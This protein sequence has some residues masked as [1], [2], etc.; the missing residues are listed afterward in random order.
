MKKL[1]NTVLIVVLSSSFALVKAQSEV[2]RDS[3]KTKEMQGV[4]IT[5]L[6]IKREQKQLGYSFQDVKG[7]DLADNPTVSVAQ[8]LYGKVAGVNISQ[9]A[10]GIASSSRV[11]IRGNRS[12]G[13]DNQPLYI[14]D[15]VPLGNTQ[16]GALTADK[17]SK[18]ADGVDNGDG[19]SSLNQEDIENISVLKGGAASALYGER[20]ANGVIIITTKKGKKN[21]FK[22]DFNSTTT[23]DVINTNYKDYQHLYGTGNNG[24]VPNPGELTTAQGAT[25]SA[26]GPKLGSVDQVRIFDGSFKPYTYVKNNIKNFFNTGVTF[27]NNISVSGGGQNI[28]YRLSYGNINAKDIIPRSEFKR[29]TFLIGLNSEF[30][31][32]SLEAKINYITEEARNRPSLADDPNNVGFSLAGLAPN[33][34]EAYLKHYQ[35]NNGNYYPWNGNAFRLNPYYVLSETSNLTNR[36]RI[37]G[38]ISAVYKLTDWLSLT[39]RAGID[40][41]TFDSSDFINSGHTWPSRANGYLSIGNL[42]FQEHNFEGLLNAQKQFGDFNVNLG[43]GANERKT[44]R[45]SDGVIYTNIINKGEIKPANF[46]SSSVYPTVNNNILVRSV[47]SYL[48]TSYK[49]YLFL[50]FTARNDWNSTLASPTG[51]DNNNNYSFFYP[52]VSSSFV[53]SDAFNLKSDVFTFGKVR[54]SWA[55]TGKAPEAPYLTSPTYVINSIPL[56]GNS[57][58]GL[59]STVAPNANLKPERSNTYEFGFDLAFFKN[60]FELDATYYHTRTSD[61]NIILNTSTTSAFTGVATNAGLVENKGIEALLRAGIFRNNDNGFNWDVTLNFAANNNKLLELDGK[62]DTQVISNARWA[63]AQIIAKVGESSSQIY[64]KKFKRTADGQIILDANGLPLLTDTLESLGKAVPDWIGG[65]VNEFS[66]KGIS[67]RAGL[68]M[69]FGGKVYSMTNAYAAASGLTNE[70]LAGREE[71]N[72]WVAQQLAAG[73]TP[74]EIASMQP[75]AGLI[76]KGVIAVNNDPNQPTTYVANTK[77]VNPQD[78][79]SRLYGDD[80]TPEPFIYDASYIKLRELSIG[81]EIPKSLLKNIGVERIK[82]S[83]IG[84]NLWTIYSKV[85]NIDPESTYTNGNGQGFEYGSLPYR[86]SYGFNV[87]VTF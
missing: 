28:T 50:D 57:T 49:N 32:L 75:G 13:G 11:V 54:L 23:L 70:T 60:R 55:Q 18:W 25:T 83:V 76:V 82:L 48:R 14:V 8:A 65:V 26:W 52:S 51:S 36:N 85:P 74:A 9:T 69:K 29:N 67:L 15:G 3:V 31:K 53:F 71:Y 19:L 17:N 87:Q 63:G 59:S 43:V 66:Y 42:V 46:S 73:K 45:F 5:A 84:R 21:S 34:D 78:Y 4:V 22:I 16:L 44:H 35:D 62:T 38:N 12:I 64:G 41:F 24:Q 86:R 2:K 56:F 7:K 58:A 27:N 77:P 20:G 72:S 6:G 39:G 47:Y 37:I 61:Q 40:R 1:T 79:W 10:A 33:I 30:N 80:T 81:Y 68:D